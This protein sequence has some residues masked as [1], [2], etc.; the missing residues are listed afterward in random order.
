MN[1]LHF[2]TTDG[3]G[4]AEKATYRLHSA[5]RNA[6]HS[7]RMIV[8]I[9]QSDDEDV[10]A[11]NRVPD[12]QVA[13][14]RVKRRLPL[15]GEKLPRAQ[16]T[17]NLDRELEI[18]PRIFYQVGKAADI[19]HLHWVTHL[20]NLHTIR[21]IADYYQRPLVWTVMDMEPMTGGCH[22]SFGC[23][24]FMKRCGNCPQLDPTG[25]VDRSWVVWERKHRYLRDLPIVFIAPTA[26]VASRIRKSSLFGNHRVELIPLAID[27][28]MFRPIDQSVARKVLGLPACKKIIFFGA[29]LLDDPRKGMP[30]L[31]D[32]LHRFKSMIALEVQAWDNE[33]LLLIAGSHSKQ[34][35]DS[36]PFPSRELGYLRDDVTL[37]LTYQ[38]AD[39][40]VSP[41]VE[42]AGPMMIA[43]SMLCGTPVVAFDTGAAPDLIQSLENGYLATYKDS[44]DLA[45]G[46]YLLL[47]EKE[48]AVMREC[49]RVK[50][51]AK[52]SLEKV[53]EHHTAL[54]KSLSL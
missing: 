49:A 46:I 7:S 34:L 16:Y 51:V 23:E 48:Q 17:F 20:L 3:I 18:D 6:G 25:P 33:I 26:W 1:I 32:A 10:Q 8:E 42:D 41:S 19:L 30:Y 5:L 22:Y 39:I 27:T 15:L 44:A 21:Q 29:T 2:S 11:V 31:H 24:G 45:N 37:A 4:G 13:L 54:Y 50:A 35:A 12:W 28:S 53:A 43:E 14:K 36:L 40:M 47:R 9:K 38:A 52:H